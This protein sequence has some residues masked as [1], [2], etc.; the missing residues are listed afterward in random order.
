VAPGGSFEVR[1][2]PPR[3]GTFIY[4]THADELNQQPAGLSGALIVLEPGAR[5]DSATDIPI[6][7]SSPHDEADERRAVLV[8]GS[9]TPAPVTVRVGV[10]HRLRLI[11]ITTGRPLMAAELWRDASM[12]EW[13]AIA[14]DGA[15]L[16]AGRQR[17]G[18]AR[19]PISVGETVDVVFTPTS[20]GEH[21]IVVKT[22][23]GATLASLPLIAVHNVGDAIDR[24]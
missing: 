3:A 13:R 11:N 1:I 7:I 20:A 4:H 2:T 15:D 12:L 17:Q 14:K 5:W 21:R 19:Q 16:P 23:L 10:P 6:L 22:A 8:N 9:L 18:P 24:E